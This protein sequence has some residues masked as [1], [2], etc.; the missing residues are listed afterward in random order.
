MLEKHNNYTSNIQMIHIINA[1]EGSNRALTSLVE[2]LYSVIS[3]PRTEFNHSTM[4]VSRNDTGRQ[5][6]IHAWTL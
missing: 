3:D 5:T 2:Q 1:A 6:H 4:I